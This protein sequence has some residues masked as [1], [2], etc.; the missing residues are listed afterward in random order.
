MNQLVDPVFLAFKA[1]V[2]ATLAALAAARLPSPDALSAGF[3]ALI[4]TSPSVHGGLRRGFEQASGSLLGA[5][6]GGLPVALSPTARGSA[7]SLSLGLAASVLLC[8]RAGLGGAYVVV[9]FTVLYFHT[10]PFASAA[11]TLFARFAAVAVGV[12]SALLVNVTVASAAGPRITA[13][14]LALARA[15]AAAALRALAARVEGAPEGPSFDDAFSAVAE[16][17]ADLAEASRER[18]FPGA[19]RAR[20]SALAAISRAIALEETLHLCK[21]AA[22]LA[23][24]GAAPLAPLLLAG[25]SALEG[26][27]APPLALG[28]EASAALDAQGH[29]VLASVALRLGQ[30]LDRACKDPPR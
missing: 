1:A 13:R 29:A 15:S 11:E 2:A 23:A 19:L 12:G 30:A 20:V 7:L 14:R 25:A 27:P 9:G 26:H 28:E 8:F 3:V 16:L 17:R 18:L 22:L 10:M 4:C 6:F 5:L 24:Q 21:E